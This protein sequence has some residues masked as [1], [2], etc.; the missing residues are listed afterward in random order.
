MLFEQNDIIVF[1][2]DS[3]TDMGSKCPVA[4]GQ[5]DDLGVGYVRLVES[6]MV[7]WYPEINLRIINSGISG[8]TSTGLLKRF[9]RDV[10]SFNPDWVSICIGI[11]DVWRRYDMPAHANS[12]EKALKIYETNLEEM[13]LKVKD[14]VK[15]IFIIS[16]YYMESNRE[17]FMRK[18]M[19]LYVEICK[20][21]SE[22]YSCT[23]IDL[24]KMF[25]E[26]CKIQ[27]SSR[28]AWDRVHPNQMGAMMI[29][30]EFLK[31]TGFEF[32]K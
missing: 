21:L 3:V 4:E 5:F 12:L 6:M 16:P 19:D 14:T 22:K 26:F 2:G 20:K 18:I 23:F 7:A 30:R 25:E 24:Q 27:H 29:S 11:N 15:G 28:I 31:K 17:D 8:E 1:A 10:V 9:D 13:I 32:E